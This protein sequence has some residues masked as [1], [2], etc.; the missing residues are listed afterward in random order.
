VHAA[1]PGERA[2]MLFLVPDARKAADE[3]RSRGLDVKRIRT[4]VFVHDPGG[5]AFVFLEAGAE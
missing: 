2:Q 4:L 3:L 1:R 5:N